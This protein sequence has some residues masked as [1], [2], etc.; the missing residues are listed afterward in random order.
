MFISA[1]LLALAIAEVAPV[2][3][4]NILKILEAMPPS[5]FCISIAPISPLNCP[6]CLL[7]LL[8]HQKTLELVGHA[9]VNK[10]LGLIVREGC[11]FI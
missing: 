7:H 8:L 5:V 1:I 11:K 3:Q 6:W 9:G 4:L 2:K 10:G